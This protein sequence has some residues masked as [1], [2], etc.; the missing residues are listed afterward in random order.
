MDRIDYQ[1][2]IAEILDN[3][4]NELDFKQFDILIKSI[5]EAM[6][7]VDYVNERLKQ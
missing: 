5:K 4:L 7:Y 3:A 1:V 6:E 2:K